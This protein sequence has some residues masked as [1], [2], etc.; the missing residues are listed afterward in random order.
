MPIFEYKC[1]ACGF[2]N[3][4]LVKSAS[5]VPPVCP[6][7]GQK[8]TEK[9]FSSFT[10]VVREPAHSASQCRRCPN[11]GGCPNFDG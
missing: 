10:A 6:Q 4:V 3:E 7:C 1:P 8:K 5:S 9:Q 11:A 2:I